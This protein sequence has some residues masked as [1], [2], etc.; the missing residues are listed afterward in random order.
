MRSAVRAIGEAIV[1][2]GPELDP[3]GPLI[4]YVD[5]GFERMTGY[6]AHDVVGQ[7]PR[8]L[9]GSLT[10]RDVLA[11]LRSAL[12][13]GKSFQGEAVNYRKDG[14]TYTVEWLITPV[15][16]DGRV[17]H[18]V[19]AQRDVTERKRAE[20]RQ[21]RMVDELNHRVNNSLAAVQSVAAQTFQDD[22][23]SVAEVRDAFRSR[24]LALSRVHVL[25]AQEY[26]EGAPLRALVE[27]QLIQRG[28][29]AERINLAGPEVRLRPGAAVAFGMALHELRMNALR[30]GALSGPGG[31]VQLHWSINR[32]SELERLQ[33]SW[34]EEDG[35]PVLRPTRRGFGSRLIE[36][37]LTHGLRAGVRL[38]FE[39]SGLRCEVDAPLEAVAAVT[40]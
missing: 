5:P 29:T 9:Q 2:T 10:D 27:R 4:E 25:L 19:A 14:S 26:W 33:L 18:W 7:S 38:L 16:E 17:V 8:I 28:G 24:L 37:G 36:R 23:R 6:A 3:P 12:R 13:A 31:R 34:A 20:E 35:P 11:R 40:R 21:K 39:P 22:R 30:H 32:N 15:V 1:I